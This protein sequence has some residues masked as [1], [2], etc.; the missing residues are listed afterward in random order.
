MGIIKPKLSPGARRLAASRLT[1]TGWRARSLRLVELAIFIALAL[2]LTDLASGLGAPAA[3]AAPPNSA[4][5]ALTAAKPG[6]AGISDAVSGLFGRSQESGP[7]AVALPETSL[8]LTL[9]GALVRHDMERRLILVAQDGQR[10][11][12]YRVGDRIGGAEIIRIE[13]RRAV[14]LRHGQH[15]ALSL[16]AIEL[17]PREKRPGKA[18]QPGGIAPAAVT[19]EYIVTRKQV[20][21][22]LDNLPELLRQAR[23][24]PYT[25]EQGEPAG[26]RVVDVA[27]DSIFADLG[28]R[29]EDVIVAVNGMAVR[30]NLDAL[31]AFRKFRSAPA[32][33]LGLL[34][35]GREVTVD[36]S[37]Q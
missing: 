15:E 16:T 10:E 12:V 29:R 25:D 21:R 19:D 8:N 24:V 28:L 7:T 27:T 1:V 3:G 13:A 14:L 4:S 23:A 17:P 31:T 37:I 30:N 20:E 36:F 34:R 35:D 18:G 22:E 5:T 2:A 9:K 33:Q 26:F 11:R 32:V 6:D